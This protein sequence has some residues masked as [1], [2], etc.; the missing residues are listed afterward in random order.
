MTRLIAALRRTIDA[1]CTLQHIQFA[2]P[3]RDRPA[4]RC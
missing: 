4:G 1:F 3:W 2:A